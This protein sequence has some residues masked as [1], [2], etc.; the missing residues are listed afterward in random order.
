MAW[1][2]RYASVA[3]WQSAVDPGWADPANGDFS[4]P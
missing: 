1:T 3:G 4:N 2:D